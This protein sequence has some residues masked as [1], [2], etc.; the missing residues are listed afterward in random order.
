MSLPEDKIIKIVDTT[1]HTRGAS[2]E[3]VGSQGALI[4][5]SVNDLLDNNNPLVLGYTSDVLTTLTKT[6]DGTDY[7][8]TLTY[9]DGNLT[10]VSIWEEA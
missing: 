5:K 4:T 10:G 7:V 2:V 3:Q 8:K 1:T 6:V 9:T